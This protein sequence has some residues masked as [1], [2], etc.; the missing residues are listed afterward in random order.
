M[1]TKRKWNDIEN[2]ERKRI[3][4]RNAIANKVVFHKPQEKVKFLHKNKLKNNLSTGIS[5]KKFGTEM[6]EH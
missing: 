6:K 4:Y 1:E 3:P 2:A 5:Q